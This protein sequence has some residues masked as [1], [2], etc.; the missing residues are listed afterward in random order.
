[1]EVS[2]CYVIK[3]SLLHNT[4]QFILRRGCDKGCTAFACF[5]IVMMEGAHCAVFLSV[6]PHMVLPLLYIHVLYSVQSTG[7]GD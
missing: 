1:M 6:T 3:L 4:I 5:M 7:D 2:R